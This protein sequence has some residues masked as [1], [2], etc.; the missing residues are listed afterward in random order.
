MEPIDVYVKYIPDVLIRFGA[1]LICGGLIGWERESKGKPAG[2]RTSMLVCFGSA[3]YVMSVN[4]IFEQMHLNSLDPSRMASQ[5][6]TGIG[7]LG[8]G[9]ILRSPLHVTGLT[10]AATIWVVAAIGVVIGFGFPLM[11][12]TLTILVLITL[13]IIGKLEMK[14]LKE[15][16]VEKKEK[17]E[18]G[19]QI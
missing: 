9:A 3:I 17:D 18:P 6:V 14:Y 1:A 12:F 5:I 2:L 13:V 8:A 10:T 7:F 19:T 4:I 15:E 16:V 11:A